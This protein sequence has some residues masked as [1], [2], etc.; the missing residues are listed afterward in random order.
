MVSNIL[1]PP[2]PPPPPSPSFCELCFDGISNFTTLMLS[3]EEGARGRWMDGCAIDDQS[4]LRLKPAINGDL[5]SRVSL[6]AVIQG[7]AILR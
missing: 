5:D 1:P 2:P 4:H 6:A 7:M 3:I